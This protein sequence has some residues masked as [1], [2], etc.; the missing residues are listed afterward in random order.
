MKP[1]GRLKRDILWFNRRW[2]VLLWQA[3]LILNSWCHFDRLDC[4][5]LD[6]LLLSSV[7]QRPRIV[8]ERSPYLK[9]NSV[10][11]FTTF[12][13]WNW[14]SNKMLSYCN[15]RSSPLVTSTIKKI[16]SRASPTFK[17][18]CMEAESEMKESKQRERERARQKERPGA[19]GPW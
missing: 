7:F 18:G 2:E 4:L 3:G 6:N 10:R 11:F 16:Q 19:T 8:P 13:L 14:S 9:G 12:S 1:Q 15:K 17:E 5:S